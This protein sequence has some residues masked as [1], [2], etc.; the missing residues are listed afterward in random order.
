MLD[1]MED[2]VI[3]ADGHSYERSAITDWLRNNSTSPK[4]NMKLESKSLTP[5]HTLKSLIGDF[6]AR[7]PDV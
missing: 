2:P 6:R 4:T 1:L 3:A 5:N 7:N